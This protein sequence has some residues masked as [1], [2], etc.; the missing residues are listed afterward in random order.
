LCFSVQ[1]CPYLKI[2]CLLDVY[3]CNTSDKT[4]TGE[5]RDWRTKSSLISSHGNYSAMAL[6]SLEYV[7][8]NEICRDA[9]QWRRSIFPF[10]ITK[11]RIFTDFTKSWRWPSL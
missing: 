2:C 10:L 8:V 11:A 6:L 9:R 4:C 7:F 1:L 3:R 5:I